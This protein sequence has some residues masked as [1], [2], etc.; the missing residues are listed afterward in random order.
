[1]TEGVK[2]GR[3]VVSLLGALVLAAATVG[4]YGANLAQ[5]NLIRRLLMCGVA[6]E[7]HLD[8]PRGK[9]FGYEHALRRDD[10]PNGHPRMVSRLKHQNVGKSGMDFEFKGRSQEEDEDEE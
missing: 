3:L 5:T 8:I 7:D 4:Y 6:G 10:F 2:N 1:M 9:V